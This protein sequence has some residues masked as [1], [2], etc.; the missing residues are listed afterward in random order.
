ML[1][2]SLIPRNRPLL[3]ADFSASCEAS[4]TYMSLQDHIYAS[5]ILTELGFPQ[6][7]AMGIGQDKTSSIQIYNH[8]ANKRKSRHLD[9]CYNIVRENIENY[10]I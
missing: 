1:L 7:T 10:I 5:N 3:T 4:G 2:R 8:T 6:P 9:F